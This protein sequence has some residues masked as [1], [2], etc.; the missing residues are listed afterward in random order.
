MAEQ[1]EFVVVEFLDGTPGPEFAAELR[2]L[3][4][5]E[6]VDVVDAGVTGG[7]SS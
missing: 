1:V 7:V 2:R 6:A 3:T 5:D 4:V